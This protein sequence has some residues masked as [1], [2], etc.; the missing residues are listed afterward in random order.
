MDR[1]LRAG[2]FIDLY[3]ILKQTLRASVERYSLK[4]LEVFFEF[5]RKTDLRDARKSL[6]ALEYALE[7]GQ[8]GSLPREV[9]QIVESYNREDCISAHALRDWLEGIRRE[10][11]GGG[12]VIARPPLEPGDPSEEVDARRKRAV[13]LMERQRGGDDGDHDDV[14]DAE[15][16][17]QPGE[18]DQAGEDFQVEHALPA[19]CERTLTVRRKRA[20]APK[21]PAAWRT[22]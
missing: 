11:I 12:K 8:L 7:L 18:G 17:L 16:D 22:P 20:L 13:A 10:L 21:S 2:V 14:V 4:D 5:E 15:D 1:L 3:G 19:I 9:L 6:T